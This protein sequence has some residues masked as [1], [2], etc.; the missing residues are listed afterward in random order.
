MTRFS[1]KS[2][3]ITGGTSGLGAATAVAFARGGAKV[4]ICGRE[5][6]LGNEV[7]SEIET[8]GGKGF[9]SIAD[10]CSVGEMESFVKDVVDLHGGLDIAIN[11]A[12]RN[13]P[14]NR[15]ADI[16][17]E[18]FQDVLQTNLGGIFN[19]MRAEIPELEKS[20]GVIVNV[21]SILSEIPSGWMAAY[22]ASKTGVVALTQSAAEDYREKGIRIYALSPGPMATP[23]FEQALR[24]IGSHPEKYAGGLPE[25]GRAMDPS[26]VAQAILDLADPASGPKSGTNL[27][28][29]TTHPRF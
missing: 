24:D 3:L 18:E 15:L 6:N 19:A 16:P 12:G 28:F 7:L 17:S 10:V 26:H 22:S 2:V 13:N 27:I 5:E 4:A 25:G 14:P 21:A 1:G 23:M 29:D 9:L 20:G 8:L 11:C